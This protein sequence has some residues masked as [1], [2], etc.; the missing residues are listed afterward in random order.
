MAKT[1]EELKKLL[2]EQKINVNALQ[3]AYDKANKIAD[4]LDLKLSMAWNH[5]YDLDDQLEALTEQKSYCPHCEGTG[6]I[7]GVSRG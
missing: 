1:K 6:R 3:K 7:K 4:K 5:F 2:K